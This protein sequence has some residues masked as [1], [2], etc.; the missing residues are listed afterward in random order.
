[1]EEDSTKTDA[2]GTSLFAD[3][4]WFDPIE[5][6]IR[7]RVR[8]LIQEL[9]GQELDAAPGRGRY[10]RDAE[11]PKAYRTGTRERQLLGSFDPVQLS[12]PRARMASEGGGKR[13]WRSA[14]QALGLAECQAEHGLG[15]E[16]CQDGKR[17]VGRLT[18]RRNAR[19]CPARPR[20]PRS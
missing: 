2:D 8:G 14:D 18:A 15:R 11:A 4:A 9:I 16:R 20:L 6:S 12:V 13:E 3:E 1:M 7:E 10:K 5:A 19:H 17:R